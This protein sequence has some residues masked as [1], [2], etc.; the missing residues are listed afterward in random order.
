MAPCKWELYSEHQPRS[1]LIYVGGCRVHPFIWKSPMVSV[2]EPLEPPGGTLEF[3]EITRTSNPRQL[4][5]H[6]S[7]VMVPSA[8]RHILAA[9]CSVWSDNNRWFSKESVFPFPSLCSIH[10]LFLTRA[11]MMHPY[12]SKSYKIFK[13]ILLDPLIWIL[14]TTFKCDVRELITF[15]LVLFASARWAPGLFRC[16]LRCSL[17]M[18]GLTWI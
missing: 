9:Y 16:Y 2:G 8:H 3:S 1:G 5:D 15:P 4:R 7:D 17:L 14:L 10:I 6:V 13:N 18:I 11:H 12:R